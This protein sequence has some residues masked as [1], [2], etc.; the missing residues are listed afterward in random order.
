[1]MYDRAIEET[2]SL[3]IKYYMLSIANWKQKENKFIW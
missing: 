1:M 2:A 3:V